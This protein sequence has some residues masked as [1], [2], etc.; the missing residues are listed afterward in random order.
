MGATKMIVELDTGS[1]QHTFSPVRT[2]EQNST[3]PLVHDVFVYNYPF[4]CTP[5]LSYPPRMFN[6]ALYKLV[7]AFALQL[8]RAQGRI[9]RSATQRLSAIIV[10]R[11]QVHQEKTTC[12]VEVLQNT[13]HARRYRS[14][15][16]H[17]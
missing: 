10:E 17:S 6:P 11:D 1:A 3:H 8:N 7:S 12:V 16:S 4:P 13:P 2:R 14:P 5:H 9:C 15:W